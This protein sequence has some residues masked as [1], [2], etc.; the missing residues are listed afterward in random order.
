MVAAAVVPPA[1]AAAT[2]DPIPSTITADPVYASACVNHVRSSSPPDDV[3]AGG[4][5]RFLATFNRAT[6]AWRCGVR[7]TV[8]VGMQY[9]RVVWGFPVPPATR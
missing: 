6:G 3:R 7:Y 4:A 2:V 9:Q 5:K 8:Y 1:C